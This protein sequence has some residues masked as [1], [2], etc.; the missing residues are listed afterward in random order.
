MA[1]NTY[2]VI[3]PDIIDTYSEICKLAQMPSA[4]CKSAMPSTMSDWVLNNNV[5]REQ[6]SPWAEK[7]DILTYMKLYY[8]M[9]TFK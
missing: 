2:I 1:A 3:F 7:Q 6:L 4:S 5:N 8:I 9:T